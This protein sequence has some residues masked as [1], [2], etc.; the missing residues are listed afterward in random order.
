MT[1]EAVEAATARQRQIDASPKREDFEREFGKDKVKDEG[2]GNWSLTLHER[3][4]IRKA[5]QMQ[6][7]S[8]RL[9]IERG[10]QVKAKSDGR[11]ER[12]VRQDGQIG[13]AHV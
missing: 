12:L 10:L 11:R 5:H 4:D 13:R 2:N 1:N 3:E 8:R 6:E 9:D 7:G